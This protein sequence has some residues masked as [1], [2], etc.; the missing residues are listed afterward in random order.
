MRRIKPIQVFTFVLLVSLNGTLTMAIILNL[1]LTDWMGDFRGVLLSV[2]GVLLFYALTIATFRVF[3]RLLPLPVG[4]IE[5]DSREE[6]IYHV[7]LLFFL[8]FFYPVMCSG[9]VPVPI[10]RVFYQALG[11]RFGDNSYG[12]GIILDP[13]FVELGSHTILG[14]GSLIIPHVIEGG[15]LAHFP[16][17]IGNHVTIGARAVVLSDVQIGDNAIVAIGA[18]V[19]KGT[20]IP[21]GEIWGG[22]PAKRI[23]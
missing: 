15:R 23:G 2:L 4:D 13:G 3:V 22:M 21:E 20:R 14:Q 12:A 18:V 19:K 17:R 9:F 7:Y 1:P 10:M 6:F 11:A 5:P 16:V 8:L